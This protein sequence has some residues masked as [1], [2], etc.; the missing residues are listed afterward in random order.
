MCA[1]KL[2]LFCVKNPAS[3]C[4]EESLPVS[5]KAQVC[6]DGHHPDMQTWMFEEG[7]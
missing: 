7:S 6:P 5:L 2:H 1:L 4:V 3:D